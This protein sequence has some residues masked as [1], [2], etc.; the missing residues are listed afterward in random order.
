MHNKTRG[1]AAALLIAVLFVSFPAAAAP[2]P[3]RA[4]RIVEVARRVIDTLIPWLTSRI[5]PPMGDQEEPP[6]PPDGT[7][8]TTAKTAQ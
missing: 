2:R 1:F 7:E 5:S 4:Q 6:P 8:T 3:S